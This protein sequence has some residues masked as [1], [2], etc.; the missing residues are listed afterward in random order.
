MFRYCVVYLVAMGFFVPLEA[1]AVK[2]AVKDVRFRTYRAYGDKVHIHYTLEGKGAYE[3]FLRLSDDGGRT[4]SIVPRTVSGDVGKGVKP[5]RDK[6]VIWEVLRDVRRLEGDDFVFEVVAI[7]NRNRRPLMMFLGLAA[8]AA[9]GMA[10]ASMGQEGQE[11]GQ[12]DGTIIVEVP[13]PEEN[14]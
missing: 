2:E 7:R 5:G 9:V 1:G 13:D 4:F 14:R 12:E 6:R 8:A 3:V 10:V 11:D